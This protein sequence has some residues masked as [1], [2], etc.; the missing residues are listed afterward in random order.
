MPAGHGIAFTGY[1]FGAARTGWNDAE[2]TLTPANVPGLTLA[3]CSPVFDSATV[4]GTSYAPHLYASPLFVDDVNVT[5]PPYQGIVTSVVIAATSNGDAYAMAGADA[6]GANGSVTAGTLL[7]HTHLTDPALATSNSDGVPVGVLS[8]PVIDTTASPPRVY[9]A[10]ADATRGWSVF[11]LDLGSGAV[12]PGWP[13]PIVPSEV[14]A[15]NENAAP[16]SP[17]TFADFKTL[18]QRGALALS[19]D[20]AHL[21]VG[22]GSYYDGAVGW[23]LSIAT[24]TPRVEVS[25][26]GAP[27]DVKPGGDG[28]ASGGMWGAGGV[29]VDSEGRL[30]VT[31]GNSP[32]ASG[33]TPGVWG[34]SLLA[35]RPPLTLEQTYSP[36]NY[37][38]LD[39]GDVDLGGSS[40]I[41]F[42]LDPSLTSTPHL[43]AFGSKQG[44][45][46]LVDRDHLGG[47]LGAR[48]PCA[49]ASLPRADTDLSLY[50]ADLQPYYA[51]PSRGPLSV[52][53]PY[54]DMPGAN[55]VNHA[56]MRTAPALYRDPGGG[57]FLFVSGNS[58]EPN[59]LNTLARPSL[60]RLRVVL[61]PGAPAYLSI[62]AT[63]GADVLFK[64]P[65]PPVV[66]SN[67]S[68]SP[69]VWVLDENATRSDPLVPKPGYAPPLPVL[70]ALDA[71]SLAVLWKRSLPAPGGKYNHAMIAHGTVY[72]GADRVY[73]YRTP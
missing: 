43:S 16:T 65:G 63:A 29:V 52:F 36:F 54:S 4:D 3:F 37:C 44:D 46:Y 73:A 5:A 51:P 45:V 50:G 33:A 38:S 58:R 69:I 49:A 60:A 9:V 35:W 32:G 27:T 23:M 2:P 25:F 62:D 22:F 12:L 67:D 31:T 10:S 48:Q 61:A 70:Y 72:V 13:L 1:H 26:S 68:A 17:T 64:N 18:S 66:T 20:G 56:K 71:Q 53:G 14:E 6:A 59:D 21:Y 40:P 30:L 39:E 24:G 55:E 41:A 15:A 19:P 11:A 57:T 28:R 47:N 34:N 42:D 8:T 7:W